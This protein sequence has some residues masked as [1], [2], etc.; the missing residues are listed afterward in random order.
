MLRINDSERRNLLLKDVRG[1]PITYLIKITQKKSYRMI[2]FVSSNC[3]CY[4][5]YIDTLDRER[6][7]KVER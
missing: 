4:N 2:L 6:Y 3:Q 5:L 7:I 1:L